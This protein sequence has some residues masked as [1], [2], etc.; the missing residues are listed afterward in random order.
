MKTTSLEKV[1]YFQ[2]YVVTNPGDTPLKMCQLLTEGGVPR[3]PGPISQRQLGR[4]TWSRGRPQATGE[5]RSSQA[6]G[7]SPHR[8]DRDQLEA[9]EEGP[10]QPAEDRRGDPRQRQPAG[11][12]GVGRDSGDS[13]RPAAAGLAGFGQFRHQRLERPLPADH[14]PQQPAEET[15]R[16]ERAGSDHPQRE[17]DVAAVGQRAV[18]QQPLQAARARQQQPPAEVADRHDQGQAGPVPRKPAGQARR[19]FRPLRDRRRPRAAGCT[20]AVCPRKSPWS[21]TSRSSFAAQGARPRR[22]DQVA[23]RRCWSGRTRRSG[24][25]SKR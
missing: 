25:F 5:P 13:A 14:Q 3:R 16:P 18:R 22:H 7:G 12:D 1:V 17:A 4:P 19:L 8:T 21:C 15:G 2:D 6:V 11:M 23:P 24:T 20:S 10:H 9:E